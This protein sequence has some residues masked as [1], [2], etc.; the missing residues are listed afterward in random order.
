MNRLVLMLCLLL[1]SC[2]VPSTTPILLPATQPA[3][4]TSTPSAVSSPSPAPPTA[5]LAPTETPLPYSVKQL[6]DPTGFAWVQVAQGLRRPLDLQQAGDERLFVV[7]QRGII[8]V[9][10]EGNL[11]EQPFLDIRAR[12]NDGGNE[13]GLLGLAFHP[14]YAENGWFYVNYTDAKGDTVVARFHANPLENVAEADS[15][16]ILLRIEQPY[17]NHNGGGLAFGPD[18]YLYVG[19]GD[20]GSAGDPQGNAQRLD[21]RLGKLLRI[22]VDGAAPYAVPADN[23]FAAGGGLPEIWA[24]GLRNP[25]RFSFD[26]LNG[27]L[28]IGDV[29]QARWEEID[30]LPAGAPGGANFGWNIREGLHAYAGQSTE[31]FVEPVAEYDHGEGCSVTGGVVVRSPSLAEWQGV[32]LYGD[33]CTGT[34]WGLVRRPSGAWQSAALFD[35]DF[36]ITAFGQDVHGEVY[37]VDQ[38]GGVYRL[39]G[40][41]SQ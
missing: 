35:T 33:Y 14:R 13:Q 30:V 21:T 39:Q 5:T 1:V 9:L 11:L 18:G 19:T 25:W 6:P 3:G 27:D 22:D 28:Y 41:S 17:A 24:Y 32:Y 8:R 2:A 10:A 40:A 38:A 7:E 26:R 16:E 15:E 31:G 4:V 34:I 36:S 29:G 37:V 12:V 20:G 23:P